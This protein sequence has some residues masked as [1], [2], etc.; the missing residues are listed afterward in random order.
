MT[1]H[2]SHR[3]GV[4]MGDREAEEVQSRVTAYKAEYNGAH[5]EAKKRDTSTDD[6]DDNEVADVEGEIGW[7]E[8][9]LDRLLVMTPDAFETLARFVRCEFSMSDGH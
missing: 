1:N 4:D 2:V 3:I 5:Y 9:L 6:E 7:K 8:R